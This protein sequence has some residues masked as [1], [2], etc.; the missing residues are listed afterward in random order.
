MDDVRDRRAPDQSVTLADDEQLLKEMGYEQQLPRILRFWTNWAVG[1]A[2]ISPIVGLYTV[3]ALNATT[4][5][6]AWVWTVP[7]VLA[8]Q[9]LVALCYTQLAA[10]WPVAGGI[11]QWSRRLVGPKF[12]WWAGWIYTWALIVTL[13]LVAYAGGGFLAELVGVSSPTTAQH[14]LFALIVMACFTA[15][16]VIGLQMLR[17]TVNIGIACELVASVGVGIALILGFRHQ[18]PHILVD[19]SLVPSGTHFGPAFIA[20]LAVAGWVLLG[21]DA[22]GALAEETRDAARKVPRAI[23]LSI[24][25][26]GIVDIIAAIGLMLAT[27]NIGAV[28]N[29]QV[30]DPVS[31]AVTSAFGGWAQKPF[32]AI[33]VTSFIACGIAVQGATVRVVYSYSRDGMLPLS[34]VWAS[35]SKRNSSPVYAV[36]L[37]AVLSSL[38]FLYANVLSVLTGLATGG[39]YLGFAFP[40]VGFLYARIHNRWTPGPSWR[41]NRVGLV[42]NVAALVWLTGE[43]IN[44]AWPRAT[45]LPWYQNWAVELGVGII[46]L[47]GG[48]YF[49]VTRP[50]RKFGLELDSPPAL[51]DAALPAGTERSE[52]G[53]APTVDTNIRTP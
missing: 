21:F 42:L 50:D 9:T 41:F 31:N 2:F 34:R 15:V 35:V 22:C 20:A 48:I 10:R 28:I 5:G 13:A 51:S 30:P 24:I 16:N 43:F 3:V 6:P 4:A 36:L 44:I 38:A 33:V 29:G 45:T 40:I 17:F 19:T 27:P 23:V 46:A 1:F 53:A 25:S 12:G 11:Y 18:S 8:G 37:V 26:V 14:I 32:L 39:Y 7:I 52:H 49:A 47:V